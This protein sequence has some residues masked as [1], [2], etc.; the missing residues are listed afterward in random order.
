MKKFFTSIILLII[1]FSLY[2]QVLYEE[3]FESGVFP[4]PG[5]S[6]IDNDG[7]TYCWD[8]NSLVAHTGTK[9]ASSASWLATAG[10][11]TPDNFLITPQINLAGITSGIVFT[12][13]A[14]A[15]DQAWAWDYYD[16]IVSTTGN[17]LND[18]LNGDIVFSET[19]DAYGVYLKREINLTSYAGQQIFI[20]FRHWNCTDMFRLN[21]DDVTVMQRS[22][23]TGKVFN[24]MNTNC[25]IDTNEV[26]LSNWLVKAMPGPFYGETHSD[27]TYFLSIDSGVYSVSLLNLS[28]MWD[29]SCPS[30]PSTYTLNVLQY[31]T[32]YNIDF[33]VTPNSFCTR[34]SVDISTWA[35][36]PCFDSHFTISYHNDGTLPSLNTQIEVELDPNMTYI[37]GGNLINQSGNI[38]TFLVDSLGIGAS[39]SF[40][41]V[42]YIDCDMGLLGSTMCATAH[43][44]PDTL[45]EAIDSTWDKSSIAVEG[46]CTG[47]S[48]ACFTIYNTGDPILGDMQTSSEYRIYENA[49]LVYTGT[50]QIAGGDSI[51]VCWPAYGNTIRLEADQ[52]PAHPGNSHPNDNVEMCG[53]SLSVFVTGQILLLPQDDIDDFIEIFCQVVT[54]SYDPNDKQVTPAGITVD[55]YIEADVQ[56]EYMIRFQNTGTDTAFNVYI[57]DTISSFLDITTLE[58]GASSHPYTVERIESNII[59]WN[60]FNILLPDSNINEPASHGFI[61]YKVN[62]MPANPL[63]TIITNMAG[64]IFDFNEPIITNTT[65]NTIGNLD[66][67]VFVEEQIVISDNNA[68]I[69]PNPT[70]GIINI[71]A[72]GLESIEVY[73]I[74]GQTITVIANKEKQS[75]NN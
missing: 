37:S 40:T 49:I 65:F 12:Y 9:C 44:F 7:D 58:S 43:I 18:F 11:L 24:E 42:V 38:L 55:N 21:I 39:G 35:I 56:L 33:G 48:L 34:N 63:E 73:N 4:P 41:I 30:S 57:I 13:W 10:A 61:K 75:N 17:T 28:T 19:M 47:D 22:I 31:D 59:Q 72:E 70:T 74:Q 20:A 66:E 26:G 1:T 53:D 3:S 5:W 52:H 50:F 62:Q 2:S 60:F 8:T 71:I 67:I 14:Y 69:Y 27:G 45:C 46:Y 25:T 23:I 68:I 15:E 32:I 6:I 29:Q 36:R 16:V 54:G 51:I 64:I